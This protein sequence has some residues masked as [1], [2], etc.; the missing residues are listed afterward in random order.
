MKKAIEMGEESTYTD[1]SSDPFST[2]PNSLS[3]SITFANTSFIQAIQDNDITL[4]MAGYS[5]SQEYATAVAIE[6]VLMILLLLYATI[7]FCNYCIQYAKTVSQEIQDT[8]LP[9]TY[10]RFISIAC[11]LL[12]EQY[13]LILIAVAYMG[14]LNIWGSGWYLWIMYCLENS[15]NATIA[16][17][18]LS[19]QSWFWMILLQ[20]YSKYCKF[21]CTVSS[22]F[23]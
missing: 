22:F 8:V 17:S 12:P 5:Y 1:D 20:S 4:I 21:H 14:T 2:T 7:Q 10:Q 16:A 9:Y 6:S 23:L 19:S 11:F 3:I 15:T 13:Y 18:K